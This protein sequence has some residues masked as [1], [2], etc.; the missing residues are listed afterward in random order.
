MLIFDFFKYLVYFAYKSK[1]LVGLN[2]YEFLI[3][4]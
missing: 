1:P 4:W 2:S 3:G